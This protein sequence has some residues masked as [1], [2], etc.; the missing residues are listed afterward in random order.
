[1]AH[2]YA[3]VGHC[4][5][6]GVGPDRGALQDEHVIP[7]AFNGALILPKSSCRKCAHVINQQIE[8]PVLS[9]E[10]ERF[11]AKHKLPTR[12]PKN[13]RKYVRLGA[14]DGGTFRVRAAEY[15]A[16]VP[17]Y[18]CVAS[19][20]ILTG[21]GWI[22][23]SH[24][25]RMEGLVSSDEEIRLQKKYP[26]WDKKHVFKVEPY[27]FMR[28]I[29]KIGHGLAVA[30][31]GLDCFTPLVRDIILGR[32]D[33]YFRFVGCDDSLPPPDGEWSKN[34]QHQFFI[35][36]HCEEVAARLV[37]LVVVYV[38]LFGDAGM[39]LYHVVAGEVDL[40]NQRQC[41]A[42]EKHRAQGLMVK[43]PVRHPN[44]LP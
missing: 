43:L 21:A 10:W 27:R 19:A 23:N 1:M 20:R 13:R 39:P 12:R 26:R 15:T 6:C 28:F 2:R 14:T 42:I 8:N 31:L 29:A 30:N 11:R 38:K 4:I 32:S 3:P 40:Q 9:Q 37:L 35:H 22:P 34:G 41:S 44:D 17:I 18:R 36:L 7:L 33:D 16:P 25:W 24:A 5:Y